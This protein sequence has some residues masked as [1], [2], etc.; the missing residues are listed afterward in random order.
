MRD[1]EPEH[2]APGQPLEV[3]FDDDRNGG[4]VDGIL[5]RAST[6]PDYRQQALEQARHWVNT[7]QPVTNYSP[8]TTET[9]VVLSPTHAHQLVEDL[10]A[11]QGAVRRMDPRSVSVETGHPLYQVTFWT[12]DGTHSDEWI[13]TGCDISAVIRWSR[14][15]VRDGE[16]VVLK[17]LVPSPPGSRTFHAIRLEGWEPSDARPARRP[18]TQLPPRT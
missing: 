13:L 15:H 12:H 11:L 14:Q 6:D 8:D 9:T 10:Q 4:F 17:V 2:A 1:F 18:L 5:A 16:D 7:G 3:V